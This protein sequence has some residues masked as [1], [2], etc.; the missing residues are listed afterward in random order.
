MTR[1]ARARNAGLAITTLSLAEPLLLTRRRILLGKYGIRAIRAA[2][3][4]RIGG[5]TG[6]KNGG[7]IGPMPLR[8][9]IWQLPTDARLTGGRAIAEWFTAIRIHR[10]IDR[11][12]RAGAPFHL[13]IDAAALAANSSCERL[14]NLQA[15]IGHVVRRQREEDCCESRN[16]LP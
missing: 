13:S 8:F 12:I 1:A 11:R 16:H 15:I 3:A 9:G 4:G 14:G 10:T 7:A 2:G 5:A 6:G